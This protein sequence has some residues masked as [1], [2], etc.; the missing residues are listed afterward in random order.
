MRSLLLNGVAS[1]ANF[2]LYM[3]F[4]AREI[5]KEIK[6]HIRDE[7]EAGY[8]RVLSLSMHFFQD[9]DLFLGS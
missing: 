4:P 2:A 8:S 3:T 1:T 6:P 9:T 7:V 5:K